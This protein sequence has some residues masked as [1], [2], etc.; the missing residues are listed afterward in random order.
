MSILGALSTSVSG[1]SAQSYALE[2]ISG[3]IANASTVG[4]KRVDTS[5][6]D[7]IPDEPS[8]RELAGSVRGQSQL[9]T[10]LQGTIASTGIKTNAAIS[11]DGYFTVSK[12]VGSS[13]APSFQSQNLYTRRGDFSQDQNG[14]LVNG[15]GFFLSGTNYNP[16]TGATVSGQNEPIRIS[17]DPL[18]AKVTSQINYSGNLPALPQPGSYSA[19]VAGS[20]LLK[21]GGAI[22]SDP[23]ATPATIKGG[24]EG[25]AFLNETVSG[26][27]VTLYDS[28]GTAVTTN[29]RWGKLTN[30]DTTTTPA[31]DAKWQLFYQ[32]NPNATATQTAWKSADAAVT[33]DATGNLT[34]STAT[35]FTAMTVNGSDLVGAVSLNLGGGL[36]QYGDSNGTVTSSVD[37]NGYARG[38]L[39][40]INIGSDGSITGSYSNGQITRLG[41]MAIA[42]FAGDDALKREDGG[43]YTETIGSGAPSFGLD[44]S[45]IASG[46]VENSNTD[47]SD[48]FSKMIVTQ[49]AYSA[50]TKV[51][52]TAQSMLQDIIN[53]IR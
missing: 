26:G 40:T 41:Q 3:N 8:K 38:T 44:G 50:N 37:Q 52:S 43:A 27:Q 53:I 15:A 6:V 46:S 25:D 30:A 34:S 10:T 33:F 51:L 42:H 23:T 19:S 5:F 45:T 21:T 9:T 14:Y 36:T 31:T 22:A 11:G 16:A 29:L 7:L 4:F 13:V 49:Q 35:A 47:I 12:N 1:L 18:P 48:E 24:A 32:V 17:N 39:S 28:A 2:N 20:E